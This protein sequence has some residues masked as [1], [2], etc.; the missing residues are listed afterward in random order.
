MRQ[1]PLRSRALHSSASTSYAGRQAQVP[2]CNCFSV[3]QTSDHLDITCEWAKALLSPADG[4]RLTIPNEARQHKKVCVARRT[5]RHL[6]ESMTR[7]VKFQREPNDLQPQNP[8]CRWD[9]GKGLQAGA[10][11][12]MMAR[13]LQHQH[14]QVCLPVLGK[15]WLSAGQLCQ[16]GAQQAHGSCLVRVSQGLGTGR[17]A[18]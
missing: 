13:C 5:R 1:L 7:A 6:Q 4:E 18:Q 3:R 14:T 11:C 2:A 10:T 17:L 15:G 8:P 16:R 9:M 12:A